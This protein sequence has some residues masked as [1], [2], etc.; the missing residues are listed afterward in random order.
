MKPLELEHGALVHPGIVDVRRA[1][2]DA[3][4]LQLT[5][6][7]ELEQ[8]EVPALERPVHGLRLIVAVPELVPVLGD[9]AGDL[10][11]GSVA[12]HVGAA[13]HHRASGGRRTHRAGRT[14]GPRGRFFVLFHARAG[15]RRGCKLGGRRGGGGRGR[16][17]GRRFA[18]RGR[19]SQERAR[20]K[21]RASAHDGALYPDR[22][23]RAIALC[24]GRRGPVL[25]ALAFLGLG[26]LAP[27]G[28]DDP[29]PLPD[30]G[31]LPE[32]SAC[33]AARGGTC[34]D[35]DCT[36]LYTCLEHGWSLVRRCD[37]AASGGSPS[38]GAGGAGGA[39]GE[40]GARLCE[41][42]LRDPACV[43]LQ[44][45]DCDAAAAR[46]CPLQACLGSCEVFLICISSGWS[47]EI[48]GYC[49]EGELV[50]RAPR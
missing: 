31:A 19:G 30:C 9:D 27:V 43:P 18:A 32:V 40:G 45:P 37:R 47:E 2:V 28:C 11:E 24:M 6:R 15:R 22:P 26:L 49:D 7:L 50:L 12:R 5:G 23:T 10:A 29:P 36:A 35:R 48:A 41:Q 20:E 21:E 46:S 25:R 14:R 44:P 34:D 13:V 39:G 1:L 4:A 38:G 16:G 8:Q 42:T 17:G 33:P 3:G